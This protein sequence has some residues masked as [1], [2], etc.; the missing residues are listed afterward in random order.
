MSN[1]A[2][3]ILFVYNRSEHT[4]RTIEALKK[5]FEATESELYIFSDKEKKESEKKAVDEVRRYIK[6]ISGFKKIQIV[7][8]EENFGLAKS[9]INGVTEILK[10]NEKVI[11][12]EDDLVTSPY[13]LRYMNKALE[14]YKDD[15]KVASIHGYKYPTQTSLPETFFIKGA[16]CWGWATWKRAWKFFNP[17]AKELL[18]KIK[19]KNLQDEFD[20]NNSFHFTRMLERQAEGKRDAWAICW[21]ASSFLYNMLTL[22]PG[23]SLIQNIG[24]D[25]SGTHSGYTDAYTTKISDTEINLTK[26]PIEE[27]IPA[28]KSF[29]LFFRSLKPSLYQRIYKK[30]RKWL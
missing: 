1:L 3:I 14:I 7:E 29:E 23:R 19:E 25:K 4:K 24:H 5:N 22:Y 15:Q 26:I 20:F 18:N 8:R 16:D 9:I 17:N 21:Y 30:L 2:P 11:V 13:F 6:R 12:L 10:D 27:N 28:R